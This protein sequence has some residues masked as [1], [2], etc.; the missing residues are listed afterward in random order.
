MEF[1][2]ILPPPAET[3]KKQINESDALIVLLSDYMKNLGQTGVWVAFEVGLAYQKGINIYVFEPAE[4][5]VD[6]P[7]PYCNYYNILAFDDNEIPWMKDIFTTSN[8]W[9]M[10]DVKCPYEDCE[11]KF[12]LIN[13]LVRDIDCPACRRPIELKGEYDEFLEF[14]SGE[15]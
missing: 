9:F 13:V 1:E 5:S 15:N 10:I 11:L 8:D 3:I 12:K 2:Y 7:I 6:F 4:Y 14:L